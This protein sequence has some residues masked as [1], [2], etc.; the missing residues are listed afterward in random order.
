MYQ[1]ILASGRS[2]KTARNV[3][4]TIHRALEQ[5]LRWRLVPVNVADLVDPPRQQPKE[6]Q[7]FGSEEA[8]LV[9]DAAKG[10]DLE[11]LWWLALTAG[12]RQGELLALRWGAVDLDR[13]SVSVV[14]G[15]VRLPGQE[16]RLEEPKSRRSRRQVELSA[17]ALEA[18]RRHHQRERETALAA[19]RPYD[20]AG[21]VFRR[22]DER[23][24]SV[25]TTLKRWRRLL[26]AAQVRP[27]PRRSTH[28]SIPAPEPR[29]SSQGRL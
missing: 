15:M 20:R 6:M 25:K 14:A 12:L 4:V 10:D 18:L 13:G 9:L 1:D 11:A 22:Q 2:P 7:A 27:I 24:L 5:A 26:A 17:G 19:G 23:P 29:R 16:P 3:H 21:F 8:R 28:R